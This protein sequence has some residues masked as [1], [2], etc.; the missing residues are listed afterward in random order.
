MHVPAFAA[1][2]RLEYA[3]IPVAGRVRNT[4]TLLGHDG[5]VGTKTGSDSAAGGCL[6]FTRVRHVATRVVVVFGVV[7]GQRGGALIPAATVAARRLS[8]ALLMATT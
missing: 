3:D 7:L 1:L 2:V 6:A 4:N 5:F 8:D